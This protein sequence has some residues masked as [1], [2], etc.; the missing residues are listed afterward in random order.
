MKFVAHII[1]GYVNISNQLVTPDS[2]ILAE[3]DMYLTYDQ[4]KILY[5]SERYDKHSYLGFH[6][7][8]YFIGFKYK[9][10]SVVTPPPKKEKYLTS[11]AYWLYM[12]TCISVDAIHEYYGYN[13]YENI[14]YLQI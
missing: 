8:W 1:T 5:S 2:K 14:R 4:Y 11:S 3:L 12:Y 6:G 9:V 7:H 10:L 13:Q